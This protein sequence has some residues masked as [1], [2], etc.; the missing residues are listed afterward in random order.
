MNYARVLLAGLAGGIV[1]W[2]ADF[3]MHGIMLGPTYTRYPVFT[4]E[5]ASP[6]SF[7]LVEV[8]LALTAALLFAKTRDS[9]GAGWAGG[10]N[11]G[12]YLGLVRF[13]MHFFSP[14]TLEGFPYYLSWCWG[15]ITLIDGVI[16]GAI[17][18]VLYKR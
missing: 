16:L 2:L 6:F 11:F 18:G 5:A 4:Q 3:V 1:I 12:V 13:F 7:L 9:W 10:A 15:G 17:L 8:F 14:L